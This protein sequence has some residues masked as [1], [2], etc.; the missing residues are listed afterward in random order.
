MP[1]RGSSGH[2][3]LMME[4][5]VKGGSFVKWKLCLDSM[6]STEVACLGGFGR[7]GFLGLARLASSEESTLARS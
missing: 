2:K 7:G 1:G 4:G 6:P 3:V 5:Y